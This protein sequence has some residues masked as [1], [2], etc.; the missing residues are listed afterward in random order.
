MTSP[1]DQQPQEDNRRDRST[2]ELVQQLSEQV[3]RLIRDELR[4]ARLELSDKGKRAGIGAGLFGGG[5][6]LGAY[7]VAAV[8]AAVALALALVLPAWAAALIVGAVLLAAAGLLALLGRNQVR[9][10]T[11][12]VPQQTIESV[13]ADVDVVKERASR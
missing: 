4:L 8:I 1:L 9:R 13:K 2:G 5:G 7:G 3:S 6:L 11:P 10:A 12:P